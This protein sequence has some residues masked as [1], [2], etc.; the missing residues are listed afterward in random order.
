MECQIVTHSDVETKA[1]AQKI[2]SILSPGDVIALEGDLGAGKTTFAQGFAQALGI[3]KQIDSPTFTI[4]KEYDSGSIPL[5]HMDV[6][7]LTYAEEELGLEEYIYGEG[8]CLI[9]W[10]SHIAPLLP[11]ETIYINILVQ[12]DQS[13]QLVIRSEHPCMQQLCK[14]LAI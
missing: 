14:E 2:A 12:P 10:A 1:V 13:R 6:Y 8:I 7:R 5:Y 3:S 11:P 9:E 4:I